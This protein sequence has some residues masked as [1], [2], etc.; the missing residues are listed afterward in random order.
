M[1]E[2][3]VLR[4]IFAPKRKEVA[5]NWRRLHNELHNLYDSPNIIWVIKP[6]WMKWAVDLALMRR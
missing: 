4:G 3:R 6:R 2:N 1:S 5:G